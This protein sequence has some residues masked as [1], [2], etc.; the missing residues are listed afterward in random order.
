MRPINALKGDFR[1]GT[2]SWLGWLLVAVQF[3]L[4]IFLIFGAVTISRQ[5][6]LL[7]DTELGYNP[8]NLVVIPT[9]ASAPGDG[10]RTL[11]VY[12]NALK[13][14]ANVLNVCGTAMA[15]A[16]GLNKERWSYDRSE[17]WAFV[18]RVDP[19][20][21]KTMGMTLVAGRDFDPSRPSDKTSAVILNET[22]VKQY[23]L[24][25]GVGEVLPEYELSVVSTPGAGSEPA[26]DFAEESGD[27]AAPPVTVIG[28]VKDHNFRSLKHSVEPM[29]I[30]INP[31]EWI[32]YI[33]VRIAPENMPAAMKQLQDTW[34]ANFPDLPYNPELL[35]DMLVTQYD[36]EQ[37]WQQVTLT[38][39]IIAIIIACMG[40]FGQVTLTIAR[41][42][43]EIGIRK[44]LGASVGN[45]AMLLSARLLTRILIAGVISCAAAY[46]VMS[47]WLE[48]FPYRI[49]L[50]IESFVIAIGLALLIAL[51][52]AGIRT[53]RAATANPTESL[54]YE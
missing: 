14:N 18:Y 36:A 35:D 15:F 10:E 25:T 45:V 4:T 54:R 26:R 49:E 3:A 48:Q 42:T 24:T 29:L 9:N 31:Q 13:G 46:Y 30:H 8:R 21:V 34:R 43:K 38:A 27:V 28:V 17:L 7:N 52:T 37:R 41:R 44:V 19:D 47:R 53:I 51:T 40:L 12:R 39:S 32:Q 6:S 11:D 50:G 20:Y 22:A 1:F 2:I 16:E 23:G 5:M 33:L